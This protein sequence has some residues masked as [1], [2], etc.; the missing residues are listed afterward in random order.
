MNPKQLK[1]LSKFLSL[2]L[3]HKPEVIGIEMDANGWVSVPEL[4]EKM[5]ASGKSFDLETLKE[6]VETNNKKR[7][8]FNEDQSMIR[9]SQGHSLQ[10]ELGYTE[11]KPPAILYHGT[12]KKNAE[13]ILAKGVQKMSRHHVHLSKD[14][15]TA[16]SVGGRHG[17]PIVFEVLSGE[18][19][20]A[21]IKFFESENGVWLTD[22]VPPEY[23][24]MME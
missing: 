3:R 12:A 4:L 22:S 18:M 6:V 24:R 5:N 1:S 13:S 21:G 14:L 10:I 20:A 16:I 17:K 23:L 11:K 9:A 19:A 8:S 2:V 15:S 7:F